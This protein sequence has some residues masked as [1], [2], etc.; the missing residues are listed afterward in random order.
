MRR[1]GRK[2]Y[3]HEEVSDQ[4][5]RDRRD[6]APRFAMLCRHLSVNEWVRFKPTKGDNAG[7]RRSPL[8]GNNGS[9]YYMWW[10]AAGMGP[11]KQLDLG[12][13]DIAI[14]SIRHH[15]LTDKRLPTGELDEYWEFQFVEELDDEE[16]I[17]Q[18]WTDDQ[19]TFIE[20]RAECQILIGPPGSG[21]TS[22]LWRAV[23]V[24]LLE[25]RMLSTVDSD[26]ARAL[27]I[28]WSQRLAE[29]AD[30]YFQVMAPGEVKVYDLMSLYTRVLSEDLARQGLR[31]SRDQFIAMIEGMTR[32]FKLKK[33]RAET[34]LET[35]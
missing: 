20:E 28:T 8:G 23:E 25:S 22:S 14:R 10:V 11:G 15:D 17:D 18:P 7:W 26:Q 13:G 12:E 29:K 30:Q 16:I 3:I 34:C 33:T 2:I 24:A 27:Y 1:L 6:V 4:L 9:H 21:K 19:R 31:E 32:D 35:L 5:E